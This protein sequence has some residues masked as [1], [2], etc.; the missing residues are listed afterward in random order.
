MSS[1]TALCLPSTAAQC[2]NK[3][4]DSGRQAAGTLRADEQHAEDSQG[5][6]V[7][8]VLMVHTDT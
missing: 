2:L 3:A 8:N 5:R 7:E 4:I 6:I 1:I